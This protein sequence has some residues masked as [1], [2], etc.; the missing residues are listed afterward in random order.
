MKILNILIILVN[1]LVVSTNANCDLDLGFIIDES[2]SITSTDFKKSID[3][4]KSVTQQFNVDTY[5]TRVSIITFSS[6]AVQHFA[7]RDWYGYSRQGLDYYLPRIRQRGGGTYTNKALDLARTKM[8]T[9]SSGER[10]DKVNVLVV[11]SDGKSQSGSSV[12]KAAADTL[13]NSGVNILAVGVGSG[14]NNNELNII[15][16]SYSNI[17]SVTNA[18]YLT[19]IVSKIKSVSCKAVTCHYKD[20]HYRSWSSWSATCGQATRTR[21]FYYSSSRSKTQV[22]GCA[23]LRTTCQSKESETKQLAACPLYSSARCTVK[24]C[25]YYSWSSWSASCGSVYRSRRYYYSSSSTVTVASSSQCAQYKTSCENYKY[26]YKTL[27]KCPVTCKYK[28]CYYHGWSSWSAT[29]GSVERSRRF[30]YSSDRS[31]EVKESKDCDKYTKTCEQYKKESKTLSKCPV[32]CRHKDCSYYGWGSWSATCGSVSRSRKLYYTRDT[33]TYVKESTDCNKYPKTCNKYDTQRKTLNKC[34]I[35]CLKKN[36][37]YHSWSSWSATCGNGVKRTRRLRKTSNSYYTVKAVSEC[38][39]YKT[40]CDNNLI[41]TK[42]LAKCPVRCSYKNCYYFGWSSWSATCGSVK[43]QR[44]YRYSRNAVV[45]VKDEAAC[46]AY[47]KTCAS[48]LHQNKTLSVCPVKCQYKECNYNSWSTWSMPCGKSHR[49]R[50]LR[51]AVNKITYFYNPSYCDRYS[52]SCQSDE[53]EEKTFVECPK[54]SCKLDLG[55]ILDESGSISVSDFKK[56]TD[57]VRQMTLPFNIGVK[58]TRVSLITYS[59]GVRFHFK[60]RDYQGYNKDGLHQALNRLY[61][62]GGGT[63]T[64]QALKDANSK[65]FT[66][67]S[68]ARPDISKVLVVITDGR[69]NGGVSSVRKPADDLK[70]N[71]VNIFA[72][73]AGNNVNSHE[74]NAIASSSDHVMRI[75]SINA[76]QGILGK[77]QSA[78]CKEIE[79]KYKECVYQNWSPWSQTCGATSR[80]RQLK[81]AYNRTK[82]QHGGCSGLLTSCENMEKE[83]KTLDKCP[84][85]N[86]PEKECTLDLGAILDESGSIG[87]NTNYRKETNFIKDLAKE[88]TI[89]PSNT[90]VS[91]ITFSSAARLR[92]KFN[93]Y[94]GYN[95]KAL[96][97]A[98]DGLRWSKGG[99]QTVKALQLAQKHMFS[100]ANGQRKDVSKVLLVVTDGRSATGA[101]NIKRASDA[102]SKQGVNIIAIGVGAAYQTELKALATDDSNVFKVGSLSE[103]KNALWSVKRASCAP[104]KC[105]YKICT[106]SAWS[107]WSATCGVTAQ[108]TR[109][110][111][112]SENAVK[113]RLGGCAG[114]PTSCESR[115]TESKTLK[116]CSSFLVMC[117]HYDCSWETWSAWSATCGQNMNRKRYPIEKK[118]T[119]QYIAK[120]PSDLN[121]KPCT[122]E[123]Q[124]QKQSTKC[125]CRV[126][127]C[128]W[129][130]WSLWSGTC[131]DVKRTRMLR[132]YHEFNYD[133]DCVELQSKEGCQL[134]ENSTETQTVTKNPCLK[135]C[136][137]ASCSYSEWSM[138]SAQCGKVN[139]SRDLNTDMMTSWRESCDGLEKD[140]SKHTEVYQERSQ[141]CDCSYVTCEPGPWSFWSAQCGQAERKRDIKTV[142]KTVQKMSCEGL[143]QTCPND[144][145]AE[146]RMTLCECPYVQCKAEQW[147]QWDAQCGKAKRSRKITEVKATIKKSSCVDLQQTCPSDAEEETRETLCN[148]SKAVC[149]WKNW[150]TWSATCGSSTRSRSIKTTMTKV[151]QY[152]CKDVPTTCEQQPEME[153]RKT[154]CPCDIQTCSWKPW[155]SW[156]ATCGTASRTRE[157]N[158]QRKIVEAFTCSEARATEG[159]TETET[160]QRQSVTREPCTQ[161]CKYVSCSYN[162]WSSWSSECGEKVTRTRSVNTQQLSKELVSC[163]G[164][165][166]SCVHF[167]DQSQETAKQCNCSYVD[168]VPR[169]WSTWSTFCGEGTRRRVVL[170]TR[171]IVQQYSCDGLNQ[172]CKTPMETEK[173]SEMCNCTKVDCVPEEWSQWS[174]VCG[175][176]TRKRNIE[177]ES[178]EL[179]R[180]SC[181]GLQTECAKTEETEE[182]EIPCSCDQALCSWNEW[183]AWSATCGDSMTRLRSINTQIQKVHKLSC[184][185]LRKSCDVF[186]NGTQNI[187]I[188]CPEPPQKSHECKYVDCVPGPWTEWSSDCGSGERMRE[189]L[190]VQRTTMRFNCDGLK[191]ECSSEVET[192]E[193]NQLCECTYL[194]CH[195]GTWSSWNTKCGKGHRTR[196]INVIEKSLERYSCEG[197]NQHCKEEDV[198]ERNQLCECESVDCVAAEWSSWSAECGKASRKRAI[199]PV[200]KTVK[201]YSCEGVKTTCEKDVETEDR[202]IKCTCSYVECNVGQWSEWSSECGDASR[203]RPI[204]AVVKSIQK[205]SCDGLQQTCEKDE[206]SETRSTMC[207]CDYVECVEGKWSEWDKKCGQSMKRT[208]LI[209][210]ET[211]TVQQKSCDGLIT[212]CDKKEEVETQDKLCECSYVKCERSD[213]SDWSA[214]CGIA[215][216]E[217]S[218][219]AVAAT[220]KQFS[221]DG[222][223]QKCDPDTKVEKRTT[224]CTCNTVECSYS[225]WSSWSAQC[226][227]G[228]RSRK[229]VSLPKT[230]QRLDCSNVK[231]TCPNDVQEETRKELCECE[232]VDC[233]ASSW[234]SWS[235]ECGKAQRE[236]SINPITKTVK[237]YSCEGVK[238]TCEKDVETEDRN[239]KCTCSYVECNVGQWSEWSSECGDASRSRPINVVVKTQERYSCDGLKQT[240]EKEEEVEERSTKCKCDYVECVPGDWSEFSAPC[241]KGITRSRPINVIHKTIMKDTCE[242]LQHSCPK[243]EET[244]SKDEKCSCA[245]IE[246]N[247]SKWSDWSATCGERSRERKIIGKLTT[248][249]SLSCDGLPKKCEEKPEIEKHA[250]FQC[251]TNPGPQ[252][253]G[254]CFVQYRSIGCFHDDQANP[255]PLPELILTERDPSH[256]AWNGKMID[257]H[258]WNTYHKEFICRCA[259]KA[260][261]L[262][263]AFF[264]TQFYGECWSGPEAGDTY[265][266]NGEKSYDNCIG[267]DYQPCKEGEKNCIGI[268]YT[269]YVFKLD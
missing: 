98:L 254:G 67:E 225:E 162:E 88:L 56:E 53:K 174:A 16:G 233:V 135:E 23:G 58:N 91:V 22:S 102:L 258:N 252:H 261:E 165:T 136:K 198:E 43:R 46:D 17:F 209:N 184:D 134:M 45:N 255:R 235:A 2:G 262:N 62:K 48:Y 204:N 180:L 107:K 73:G 211:K 54:A 173:R 83:Q 191:Q 132:S 123:P 263:Y 1:Y 122:K 20:C 267:N 181:D 18:Y 141:V 257:W 232:S 40:T 34:P 64:M 137:Y 253:D 208:R 55:F 160:V 251:P 156:S 163:A 205:Y 112:K 142:K 229:S 32:A 66:V 157:L 259:A 170:P 148:C 146:E 226:G 201:Q 197:L 248:V 213:W 139:R 84:P 49:S 243:A 241:G 33:I 167:K 19:S 264:S 47:T 94:E 168:C 185:G 108:R 151:A 87:S 69:S 29:C 100:E 31:I 239:I 247:W 179:M 172:Q 159:C 260:K 221:C 244:E 65:M 21:S 80:S 37:Y 28:D 79:C 178:S 228:K 9:L 30:Y 150:S 158:K 269:N 176:I 124:S 77:L 216:R 74:L 140:C 250:S 152:S 133:Y 44:R 121:Q 26:E 186:K 207:T 145:E 220:I 234:S 90:R 175:K 5:K 76:L 265:F 110:L 25:Y 24:N 193:R 171:K 109:A 86:T 237:Q 119:K 245:T 183:G 51:S 13:R 95:R 52:K 129:R 27:A 61:R 41:E 12:L 154:K 72:V 104:V 189:I 71:H 70:K 195:S 15:S 50:K 199:N 242:G 11:I 155:G 103:L 59:S 42:N 63:N 118:E 36:C 206:E 144:D 164:L 105:Q 240:C 223:A 85:Y 82:I 35:R 200:T 75:S 149:T 10:H 6:D 57:F 227:D 115:E 113:E 219:V 125:P 106:Y 194:E 99:T 153:D 190:A 188:T 68:G 117:D 130:D 143:Q 114:L 92:F 89:G 4:V 60:L 169:S 128:D 266:R 166:T 101:S 3:F 210:S 182:K 246:C 196:P 127:K 187:R 7:F 78:V 93:D 39:K 224:Q 236:R 38:S 230:V 214:S 238:T 215:Q 111:T 177:K 120:C 81:M 217:S 116:S 268:Q 256:R 97:N 202:N 138:W 212:K 8:Y 218:L 192:Q 231:T 249:E 131:G 222:L 14:I 96:Y 203:S 126:K 161:T 147:S